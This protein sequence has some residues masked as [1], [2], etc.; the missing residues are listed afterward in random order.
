[1]P[2]PTSFP[3]AF[4]C[5]GVS[6][7]GFD[8]LCRGGASCAYVFMGGFGSD[9]FFFRVLQVL[10]EA[11]GSDRWCI[12]ALHVVCVCV[13]FFFILRRIGKNK[14]SAHH[15]STLPCRVSI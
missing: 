11:F 9:V 13:C 7:S 2:L 15:T 8:C 10:I 1:M 14:A 3:A 4:L 5:S 12:F 6:P